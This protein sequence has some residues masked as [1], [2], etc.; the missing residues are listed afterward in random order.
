[1]VMDPACWAKNQ[2]RGEH[3][4]AIVDEYNAHNVYPI[5]GQ[6]DWQAG[7]NRINEHLAHDPRLIHPYTGERGSPRLLLCSGGENEKVISEW[8]NYKWKKAKGTILRNAPDEPVDHN[9][10]SID[11]TRYLL[12]VL[13]TVIVPEVTVPKRDPLQVVLDARAKWNPLMSQP[14]V[15]A[16]SWMSQ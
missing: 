6:N 7:F 11:E 15:M 16:G 4:F 10:H 9:D 5:P 8:M 3:V 1:M 2:S 12:S 13:P 14:H